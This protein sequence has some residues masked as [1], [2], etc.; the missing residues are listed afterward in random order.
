MLVAVTRR[1]KNFTAGSRRHFFGRRVG[2]I[3][4]RFIHRKKGLS[5]KWISPFNVEIFVILFDFTVYMKE[6]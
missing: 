3:H 1:S 6:N 4:L 2:G 5:N